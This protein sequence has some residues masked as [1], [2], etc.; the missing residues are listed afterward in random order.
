MK[1]Y[2]IYI[3]KYLVYPTFT[4]LWIGKLR[5]SMIGHILKQLGGIVDKMLD[6]ESG[7]PKF[8]PGLR[9][10]FWQVI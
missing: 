2:N 10:D 3:G 1:R 5:P 4:I 8:K 7:R 6:L 9:Y